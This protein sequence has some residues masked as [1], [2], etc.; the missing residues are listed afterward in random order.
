MCIAGEISFVFGLAIFLLATSTFCFAKFWGE[1]ALADLDSVKQ[2][3]SKTGPRAW[4]RRALYPVLWVAY[5]PAR[6][7][8]K[9]VF[10]GI[11]LMIPLFWTC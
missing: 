5:L 9:T 10:L 3:A 8:W 1:V 11:V 2:E 6:G 7:Y 4:T